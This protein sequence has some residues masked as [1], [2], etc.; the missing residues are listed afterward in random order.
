MDLIKKYLGEGL[1]DSYY[2]KVLI[3]KREL[4]VEYGVDPGEKPSG[5]GRRYNPGYGPEIE[6]LSVEDYK[7]GRKIKYLPDKL[8]NMIIDAIKNG[9]DY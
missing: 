8:E 9:E 7:T 2:T 1:T 4:Y 6:I 3:G 5:F